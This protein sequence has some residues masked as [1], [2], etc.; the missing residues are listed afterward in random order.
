M[1]HKRIMALL[2]LLLAALLVPGGAALADDTSPAADRLPPELKEVKKATAKYHSV[3]EAKADGYELGS[4]C[5]PGMGYHFV[6]G[7]AADQSELVETE[8]NVLVY[9]PTKNSG[10]KLVAVE[11]ASVENASL[12]GQQFDPP[13]A[14]PFYS[15][16]AWIWKHNPEG[17]FNP[18]NPR[19]SCDVNPHNHK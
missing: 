13:G 15:L 5:V 10:L 1:L 2:S 16:H 12:F 7:I 18:T 6:K 17:V 8:P 3:W 11:Y 14:V 19:V 9:A 4:P